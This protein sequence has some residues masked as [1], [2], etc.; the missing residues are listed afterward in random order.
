MYKVREVQ[1]T[2]GIHRRGILVILG[3]AGSPVEVALKMRS[4]ETMCYI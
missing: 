1:G 2:I 4:N 3:W